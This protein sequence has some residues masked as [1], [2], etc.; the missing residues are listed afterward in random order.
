MKPLR[1]FTRPRNRET[2]SLSEL[3]TMYLFGRGV[4]RRIATAAEMLTVA[5]LDGDANAL[6]TLADYHDQIEADAKDG[7]VLSALCL[8]KMYDRGLGVER[9]AAEM[10]MWLMWGGYRGTRDAIPTCG[11]SLPT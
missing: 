3:G 1:G 4:E 11:R 5:A 7:S 8:A 9:S 10:F 2:S 6:G